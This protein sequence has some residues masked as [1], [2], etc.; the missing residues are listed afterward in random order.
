MAEAIG[1][2]LFEQHAIG[3][4]VYWGNDGFCVDVALSHPRAPAGVTLGVL[5]DFTRYLKT[6]DPI[7]WEQFRSNM[8]SSQGWPLHRVWTP[9]LFRAP[10]QILDELKT[11]HEQHAPPLPKND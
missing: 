10:D 7:A 6:P 8:L 4:T 5:T 9:S 3:S 11:R 2:R 1:R